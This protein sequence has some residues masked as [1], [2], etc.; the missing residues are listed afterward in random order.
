MEPHRVL[1]LAPETKF[2]KDTAAE[3]SACVDATVETPAT[4]SEARAYLDRGDISCLVF[5]E[6]AVEDGLANFVDMVKDVMPDLPLVLLHERPFDAVADEI[7]LSTLA[8]IRAKESV[9]A[10]P[11]CLCP[12]LNRV[13]A[14]PASGDAELLRKRYERLVEQD[15]IGVYTVEDR[16]FTYVNERVAEIFGTTPEALTG[17]SVFDVVA[18]EDHERVRERICRRERGVEESS[19]YTFRGTHPEHDTVVVE[20]YGSRVETASGSLII[21]VMLDITERD[22]Y[23]RELRRLSQALEYA[24]TGVYITDT[25]SVIQYVNPA[26]ERITGYDRNEAVGATP[27]ILNSG[28]MD[29]EYFDRLYRTLEAEEVWEESIIDQRKNGEFYHAYQTITPYKTRDGETAGYV[30]IHSDITESRI[31]QQVLQVFQRLFRHNLRNK[32]TVI[33]GHL[34]LL[35][36]E[37]TGTPAEGSIDEIS[38]ATAQLDSLSRKTTQVTSALESIDET[39]TIDLVSVLQRER[40]T[41]HSEHSAAS[42]TLETPSELYVEGGGELEVAVNE[43]LTNAV[44]HCDQDEPEVSVLLT[45]DPEHSKA[46]LVIR[47]NGPGITD[48]QLAALDSGEETPLVHTEGI[49]LWLIEWV[50]TGLGGDVEFENDT[51]RGLIVTLT[52]PLA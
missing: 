39:H 46:S 28:Q 42:I 34:D 31:Q 27:Q 9:A 44:V 12:C 32:L 30:A 22:S 4:P 47:D 13:A 37:V 40:D 26:F 10:N 18:P 45:A 17:T 23:E 38:E 3:L 48:V 11:R 33:H 19:H 24:A 35:R 21:G 36:S 2:A 6:G 1:L 7:D 15:I 52:L 29:D 25:D 50:L 5:S 16:K 20:V 49:G 41:V 8:D 51:P 14:S 43:L